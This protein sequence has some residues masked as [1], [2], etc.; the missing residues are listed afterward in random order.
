MLKK[1]LL[2]LIVLL[3]GFSSYVTM[4]PNEFR[5]A[6]SL[7]INASAEAVYNQV[8]EPKK[9]EAWSPW[10][11]LDPNAKIRY[12]GPDVGVGAA[13]TWIGNDEMGEGTETIIDSIPNEL[14]KTRLDF[15]KPM[16]AT[17]IGE[18][19]IKQKTDTQ[20]EVTWVMS[21]THNF[22]AK[23]ISIVLNCDAMVGAMFEEGLNNLKTIL[24]KK[25]IE[26][27]N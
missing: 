6:R 27:D 1:F 24:E 7:V 16:Q 9:M 20:V 5:I 21:G 11:K 25:V 2:L 17:N 26:Q 10:S 22:F 14:V 12:S 19:I 3:V 8:N 23:A 15:I 4:Q 13:V 18:F